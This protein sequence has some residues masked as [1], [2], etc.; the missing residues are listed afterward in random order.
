MRQEERAWLARQRYSSY[1]ALLKTIHVCYWYSNCQPFLPAA[2]SKTTSQTRVFAALRH[3]LPFCSS[4]ATELLVPTKYFFLP[5][6]KASFDVVANDIRS[7]CVDARGASESRI[8]PC[9]SPNEFLATQLCKHV[10]NQDKKQV[11]YKI[12]LIPICAKI[13][14]LQV[15]NT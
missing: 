5:A 13:S 14:R 8:V 3:V 12:R 9:A 7:V 15:F 1:S 11:S 4:S 6:L 2:N 10:I